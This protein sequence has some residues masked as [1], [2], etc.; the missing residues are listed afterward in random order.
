MTTAWLYVIVITTLDSGAAGEGQLVWVTSST[1][2][3]VIS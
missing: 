3:E 2:R 1:P